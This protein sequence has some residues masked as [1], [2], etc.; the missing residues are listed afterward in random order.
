MVERRYFSREEAEAKVG[1][2]ISTLVAWSGVPRGTRGEVV[3]ADPVDWARPP[4]GEAG[5][6][7]DVVIEWDLPREP[8]RVRG[9]QIEGEPV[10]MITGGRPLRDWFTK[11]EYER[12]IQELEEPIGPEKAAS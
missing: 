9:G 7:Y 6:A 12:Y 8:W 1:R 2:R 5:E 10:L 3:R 11:D 4:L